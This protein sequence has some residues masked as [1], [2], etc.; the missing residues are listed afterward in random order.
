MVSTAER[1]IKTA[2]QTTLAIVSVGTAFVGVNWTV[3]GLTIAAATVNS[4]LTSIVS[5][6]T[7]VAV[8]TLLPTPPAPRR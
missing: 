8:P 3:A 6:P 7:F 4:V 5:A 1:A 2:A